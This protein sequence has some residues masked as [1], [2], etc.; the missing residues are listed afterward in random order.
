M[1]KVSSAFCTRPIREEIQKVDFND[2]TPALRPIP[3]SHQLGEAPLSLAEF[4][5]CSL[6]ARP[7]HRRNLWLALSASKRP[8]T[9]TT[10]LWLAHRHTRRGTSTFV[11]AATAILIS[12]MSA[13]SQDRPE[14]TPTTSA[15]IPS[16]DLPKCVPEAGGFAVG[17]FR[18]SGGA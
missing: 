17:E 15:S 7:R 13:T 8:N 16:I 11:L 10:A 6:L 3:H 9:T 1:Q 5:V 18:I 14:H 4:Q 12:S 2:S